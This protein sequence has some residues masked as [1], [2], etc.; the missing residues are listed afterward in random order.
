M[1]HISPGGYIN[2]YY[3]GLFLVST[4]IKLT[5]IQPTIAFNLA[6]PTVA[7]LTAGSVFS[8]A[9]NLAAY[10]GTRGQS[11]AQD[12]AGDVPD[13][14]NG[15]GKHGTSCAPLRWRPLV[16]GLLAVLLV[17]FIGNLAGFNS[18]CACWG[19]SVAAPSLPA[20]RCWATACAQRAAC[21]A[22]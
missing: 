12:D 15:N 1:I 21:Y 6:V 7:A 9:Y 10:W 17:V 14:G 16:V 11:P 4:L 5:G 13:G 18:W 19:M 8:L 2:Y 3:Y 22:W 20:C